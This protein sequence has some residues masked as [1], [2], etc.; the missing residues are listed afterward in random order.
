MN[1][2]SDY[3]SCYT[4]A[5]AGRVVDTTVT[6]VARTLTTSYNA[7]IAQINTRVSTY[8][9][10]NHQRTPSPLP[11]SACSASNC[12]NPTPEPPHLRNGMLGTGSNVRCMAPGAVSADC[13]NVTTWDP[14]NPNHCTVNNTQGI[15]SVW[16]NGTQTIRQCFRPLVTF[17]TVRTTLQEA[18]ALQQRPSATLPA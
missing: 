2:S 15:C 12:L 13:A 10:M 16:R 11:I 7:L 3:L 9:Y 4:A 14:N 18:A 6:G 17:A 1:R 8:V 5:L